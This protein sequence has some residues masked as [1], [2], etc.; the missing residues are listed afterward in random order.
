MLLSTGLLSPK[1]SLPFS[2]SFPIASAFL[3]LCARQKNMR[4]FSMDMEVRYVISIR[5]AV[6]DVKK[7][8]I[9]DHSHL[10]CLKIFLY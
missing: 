1:T 4:F 2:H 5:V 9:S 3:S 7:L 10:I 6:S 8:G